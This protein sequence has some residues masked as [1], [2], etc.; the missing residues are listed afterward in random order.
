[1]N[2]GHAFLA[3]MSVGYLGA[4]VAYWIA[5]NK[6]YGVALLCYAIAN[7]GLIYAAK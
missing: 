7:F 3:A 4:A 5:G 6:G 2:Y 1:M